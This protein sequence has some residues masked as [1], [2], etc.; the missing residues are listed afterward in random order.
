MSDRLE[1]TIN[2]LA[3]LVAFPT[4]SG[5]P[6][7]E[8]IGYI[9]S[10]LESHGVNVLLDVT[11]DGKQMNL[12]ATIGP[13]VDGG[14]ILSGHTD[15]VPASA[16]GWQSDPFILRRDQGRLYGRGAVDMKGFVA[17]ALA[18]VPDFV[19]ARDRLR[20]PVHLAFTFDEEVGCFGSARM[21]EF[22][23][24]H[25]I[26]AEMAIIG[27]PTEMR[28]FIGHKGGMELSAEVTGTSGHASK[29]AGKVNAIFYAARLIELINQTARDIA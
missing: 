29:P 22:L 27:E 14:I 20:V 6:N 24:R 4:V 3:D 16:E 7:G 11:D 17:I 25:D 23:D 13:N 19:A 15:V 28:P 26:S 9:K 10:Y 1:R 18:M 5:E 2:L 21:P 8:I 12:F